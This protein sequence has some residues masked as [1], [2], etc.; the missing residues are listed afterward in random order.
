MSRPQRLIINNVK[1]LDLIKSSYFSQDISTIFEFLQQQ[2]TFNFPQL[3][4][5]LFSAAI[6]N[7]EIESTGYDKVWIRDNIHIAHAHYV[8]GETDVAIRNVTSLMDY[9]KK[10]QWRFER[11][12]EAQVDSGQAM[13]RPHIRFDGINLAEL[14]Q[15]WGHSQNDALGY[16]LWFYCKLANEGYLKPQPEDLEIL[17]LFPFFFQAIRYWDDE[18]N[19]HWEEEPKVEASSIGVVIAGL[20]ELKQLILKE[21]IPVSACQY[22]DIP[23]RIQF[24]DKLIAQ[25]TIALNH[26]LPAECIQPE[27]KK[28]RYDA[29]LLFL[30]YPLQVIDDEIGDQI[31]RDVINNLQGDYGIK[32]YL[33]DSYWCAD[34]G[35]KLPSKSRTTDFSDDMTSRDALLK[36]GEEAQWCL[37]DPII[38][39]IFGLKFQKTRQEKYRQQQIYYL[40]RSLGQLTGEDCPFG[41]FKCPELYYLENSRYVPN[42]NTPLLW[43]QANLSIALQMMESN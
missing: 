38:S 35:Q 23:V 16:F 17:A 19:G 36:K 7:K 4:T 11:V 12:I 39:I 26:I 34:Y 6:L 33:G 24:L 9:F 31:L 28:R 1:L 43:T 20:K 8:R 25:G 41:E 32:R 3:E 37:F 15:H 40:N 13:E 14:D 29:A 2:E 42:P 22:Q 10:F 18:D 30:I 5:G 21:T 27:S